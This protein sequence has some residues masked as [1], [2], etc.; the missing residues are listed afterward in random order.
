MVSILSITTWS[1]IAARAL[2]L[3]STF[4]AARRQGRNDGG[5]ETGRE[6]EAKIARPSC[7]PHQDGET[8]FCLLSNGHILVTWPHLAKGKLGNVVFELVSGY[9][10]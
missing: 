8:N 9:P 3:T 10:E 1:K 7:L 5:W 2:A 6:V 4:Q